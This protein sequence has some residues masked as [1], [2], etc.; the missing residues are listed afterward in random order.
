MQFW[1]TSALVPLM[2]ADAH[3][4]RARVILSDD[5]E[6]VASF[7]TPVEISSS[8]WRKRHANLLDAEAHRR[9]D[10]QF[11]ALTL[12]WIT[13]GHVREVVDASLSVVSRHSLRT[14]DAIQLGAAVVARRFLG[15]RLRFVT[16]DSR[17][18]DAARAEGF[19]VVA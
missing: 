8:I 19:V 2:F 14:G 17:L 5:N 1:D 13:L 12:D 15:S 11:A 6:I 18:G 9:A 16:F 3:T 4:P 7:I 10:A